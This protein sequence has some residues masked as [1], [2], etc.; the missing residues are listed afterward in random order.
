MTNDDRPSEDD[1]ELNDPFSAATTPANS[2]DSIAGRPRTTPAR[3]TI[4]RALALF[5]A[6]IILCIGLSVGGIYGIYREIGIRRVTQERDDAVARLAK[7]DEVATKALK[8]KAEADKLAENAIKDKEAAVLSASKAIDDQR[9]KLRQAKID[10]EEKAKLIKEAEEAVELE[11]KAVE[12][13]QTALDETKKALDNEAK[14]LELQKDALKVSKETIERNKAFATYLGTNGAVASDRIPLIAESVAKDS[15]LDDVSKQLLVAQLRLRYVNQLHLSKGAENAISEANAAA[16]AAAEDAVRL[17]VSKKDKASIVNACLVAA[18][19]LDLAKDYEKANKLLNKAREVALSDPA[20]LARVDA[21][22]VRVE[23]SKAASVERSDPTKR[24]DNSRGGMMGLEIVSMLSPSLLL[25]ESNAGEDIFEN[26][27]KLAQAAF[28]L[29]D[30]K[31]PDVALTLAKALLAHGRFLGRDN[32]KAVTEYERA[33]EIYSRVISTLKELPAEYWPDPDGMLAVETIDGYRAAAAEL[34]LISPDVKLKSCKFQIELLAKA[35]ESWRDWST[36]VAMRVGVN[37]KLPPSSMSG[38]SSRSVSPATQPGQPTDDP[39]AVWR[40]N[41]LA[42]IDSQRAI[43][44]EWARFAEDIARL[45]GHL[46]HLPEA[47]TRWTSKREETSNWIDSTRKKVGATVAD[48]QAWRQ[49][50]KEVAKGLGF[51]EELPEGLSVLSDG[52]PKSP[53]LDPKTPASQW[54]S[55]L[56]HH[57]QTKLA[58]LT[59]LARDMQETLV[60]IDEM[61][62]VEPAPA[63]ASPVQRPAKCPACTPF[64]I[65]P[66]PACSHLRY[67]ASIDAICPSASMIV[68][69]VANR[70]FDNGPPFKTLLAKWVASPT[71]IPGNYKGQFA[72]WEKLQLGKLA[73]WLNAF[74]RRNVLQ[75]ELASVEVARAAIARQAANLST[76][77]DQ[78]RVFGENIA[79]TVGIKRPAP[80]KTNLVDGVPPGLIEWH[81]IVLARLTEVLHAS[82]F[83]AERLS[84]EKSISAFQ[85]FQDGLKNFRNHDLERAKNEFTKA[86]YAYPDDA[87]YYYYRAVAR[88]MS[89]VESC[90]ENDEDLLI[91]GLLEHNRMPRASVIN[92]SLERLQGTHRLWLETARSAARTQAMN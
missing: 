7:T 36:Q 37:R 21:A 43:D 24:S 14:A 13:A 45:C 52:A 27:V 40:R 66:A 63:P 25:I 78:W 75:A 5:I 69:T 22:L 28:D 31:S 39:I 41:V 47:E 30:R 60:R 2:P 44:D 57:S 46:Q 48:L 71:E 16:I 54:Q 6:G 9:E 80:A 83:S 90:V 85:Q 33:I 1:V 91:G 77:E 50:A 56:V 34:D 12:A 53:L 62:P 84:H 59:S 29:V 55:A 74:E 81:E 61:I 38:S 72:E 10:L 3:E 89:G 64:P 35:I 70:S 92:Q 49:W 82:N 42:Q 87:R 86:I 67:Q 88:R 11:K 18:A 15:V 23:L 73:Q 4:H 26:Q 79:K 68:R 20:A 8:E 32:P 65:P 19:A 58:K 17:A 76:F 51:T